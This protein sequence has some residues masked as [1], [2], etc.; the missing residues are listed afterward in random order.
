MDPGLTQ[1][2]LPNTY[3]GRQKPRGREPD[4]K[5]G[6]RGRTRSLN[7][8][9]ATVERRVNGPGPACVQ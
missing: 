4:A 9:S 2:E 5:G 6:C 8:E 7:L 3:R 1:R